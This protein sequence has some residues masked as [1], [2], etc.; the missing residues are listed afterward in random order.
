MLELAACDD[1]T[2]VRQEQQVSAAALSKE[3]TSF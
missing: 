1:I 3:A 2:Q